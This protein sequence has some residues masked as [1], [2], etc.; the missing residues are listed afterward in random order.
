MKISDDI[1]EVMPSRYIWWWFV[2][3]RQLVESHCQWSAVVSHC[4][5]LSS[6]KTERRLIAATLCG[7]RRCFL[8]DQLWSM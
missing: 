1:A 5:I 3:D 2:C 7:W 6:D 8:A 4:Q